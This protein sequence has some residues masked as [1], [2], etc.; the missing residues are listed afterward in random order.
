MAPYLRASYLDVRLAATTL[1]RELSVVRDA[2]T[3]TKVAAGAEVVEI[4]VREYA[5]KEGT[6]VTQVETVVLMGIAS[7]PT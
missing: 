3:I 7:V 1:I 2:V 6:N 5:V 4:Q